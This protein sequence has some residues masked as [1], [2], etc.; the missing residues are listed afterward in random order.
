MS[1]MKITFVLFFLL[2]KILIEIRCYSIVIE[3]T[4][5]GFLHAR[6]STCKIYDV[7]NY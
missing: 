5:K 4:M 7:G 3:T 6:Y 1:K 2:S